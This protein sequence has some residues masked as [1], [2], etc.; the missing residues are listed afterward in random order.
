M[1]RVK[2]ETTPILVGDKLVLCSSF[3][4][5]IALDPATGAQSVALR[6]AGADRPAPGQP[7]QLPRRRAMAR[8][9]ARRRQCAARRAS[10][11]APT[12]RG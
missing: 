7:L 8:P 5:V 1:K 4:E 12:M 2:F 11:A 3:N 10:S 6:S 9:F